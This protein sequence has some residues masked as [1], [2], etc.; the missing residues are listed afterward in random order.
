MRLRREKELLAALGRQWRWWPAASWMCSSIKAQT[1][2]TPLA[3]TE[4]LCALQTVRGKEA[5][6]E[7]A[8]RSLGTTC[9]TSCR[10]DALWIAN[11]VIGAPRPIYAFDNPVPQSRRRR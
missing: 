3:E 6:K 9:A 7:T 11:K 1:R 8:R 4:V 5:H 10:L 2:F